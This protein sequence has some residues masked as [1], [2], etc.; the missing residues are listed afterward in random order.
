MMV[1]HNEE[2]NRFFGELCKKKKKEGEKP[3]FMHDITEKFTFWNQ[4]N[5]SLLAQMEE[6]S[7][8]ISSWYEIEG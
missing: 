3:C 6:N 1:V 7:L 2:D 4:E 5:I 8:K